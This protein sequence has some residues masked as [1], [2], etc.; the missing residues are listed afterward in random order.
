[1]KYCRHLIKPVKDH[2]QESRMSYAQH[3]SHSIMQS[4]RLVAIAV[5]SYIHGLLPWFFAASGPLGIY[6]IYREIKKMHHVQKMF[7]NHDDKITG[8]NQESN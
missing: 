3:L 4:N 6:S 5:K 8:S 1:M 2:L 7:S